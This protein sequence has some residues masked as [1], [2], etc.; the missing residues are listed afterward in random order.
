[1]KREIDRLKSDSFDLVVIGAGIHG[2]CIARDAALRGYSVAL[3]DK[4]DIGGE[5]S[6]NS[7]KTIHGGIRYIQ[8]LDFARSLESIREREIWLR[9]APHLVA[10]LPFVMPTYGHGARGPLAMRAGVALYNG[11]GFLAG[12]SA[13]KAGSRNRVISAADCLAFAPGLP[14][15]NLTGAAIWRDGQVR[16]A[17]RAALEIVAHAVGLGAAAANYVTATGFD[18]EKGAVAAVR[19]RDEATGEV[20]AIS[21]RVAINAAGPWVH[22]VLD[23]V[24]GQGGVPPRAPLTRSMNIVT[25]RP[26]QSAALAIKSRR[27]SDS[28]LGKTNRLYFMVPWLDVTMFGTTHAPAESGE[29]V[30]DVEREIESFIAE[31]NDAYNDLDLSLDDVTYCYR[32]RTPA[33]AEDGGRARKSFVIDH[34]AE[35][36]PRQLLSTI[37][38]KW[39]TSRLVAEKT[40][41]LAAGLVPGGRA[42]AT[43]TEPVP[44][45]EGVGSGLA[46]LSAEEI[47]SV[48]RAHVSATMTR[49]LADML[50]RR[51]D[52]YARGA[53]GPADLRAVAGALAEALKWDGAERARQVEHL[54]RRW[55]PPALRGALNANTLFGGEGL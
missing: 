51:T 17:D 14:A 28:K 29:D 33:D 53:L 8:H 50:E 46:G 37:G 38:V 32:G 22:D 7:L 52:D 3:I 41:D 55:T 20:F 4:G 43:R 30:D 39:T 6:H 31:L 44:E 49:G 34:G 1:M 40:V 23:P 5:T 16:H 48:C 21:C 10:P 2:A 26:A 27:P 54:R 19:A 47:G 18:L 24:R 42:C 36:G 35:G 9:T 13:G 11:L 45:L 25:R 12:A 15:E